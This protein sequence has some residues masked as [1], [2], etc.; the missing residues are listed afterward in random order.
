MGRFHAVAKT[1]EIPEGEGRTFV[2]D[3]ALVAVFHV[4][5][6]F[7]AID[8][9][10]PHMGASLAAGHIEGEAVMCPWHAWRFS[11][12]DGTWLD[13]PK[14]KIANKCYPVRVVGD[15]VEVEMPAPHDE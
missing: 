6:E 14:S 1:H 7:T 4:G 10:C 5:G 12:K 11:V 3:G 8:D 13:N 9:T 2:I 15:S